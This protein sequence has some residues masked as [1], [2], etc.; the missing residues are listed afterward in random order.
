MRSQ[1]SRSFV[2]PALHVGKHS[3]GSWGW[4]A[5]IG[6]AGIA[7]GREG[8]GG[9]VEGAAQPPT[10]S[11][12]SST[13]SASALQFFCGFISGLRDCRGA[14]G[15]FG[16]LRGFVAGSGCSSFRAS[17]GELG[18]GLRVA[19]LLH[20]ADAEGGHQQRQPGPRRDEVQ[21]IHDR[22][23]IAC[24]YNAGQV[25]AWGLPGLQLRR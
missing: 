9:N 6:N 7:A 4:R 23:S 1:D 10:S 12:G 21:G 20:A 14:A 11:I 15:F 17:L 3:A 25:P 16:A 18:A 24:R 13:V 8:A 19:R 2:N 22:A 5:S